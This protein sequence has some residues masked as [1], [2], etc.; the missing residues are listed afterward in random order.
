MRDDL[1][2]A[3]RS[4]RHSPTFTAVALIVLALGIGAATAIF[5]VVDAVVLRGLPFDEHD[6]IVGVLGVDTRRP[7]TFG[8]GNSTTQT[9]LDWRR[10]QESFEGLALV[11]S[12][13]FRLRNEAGEPADARA[14]RITHEFFP[15]L[16]VA[17]LLGRGFTENDEIDGS[18]K[19]VVLSYGFWQRRF[20]GA[21]DVVGKTIDLNEEPW[22]IV[23]VMPRNFQY[24]VG[25]VLPTD[26]YVPQAF[27]DVDKTRGDSHNYNGIAIGRL[28]P[29]I[30]IAQARDQMNRVAVALDQQYPKWEPGWR[31]D[32]I[33]LHHYLVGKVRPWML[34]LLGA[35]GL[36]LL[37]ACA[38]VA[39]LMLARATVRT[40][41]IG[42]RAALGATR[43]RLIR[44]LI[45]EGL[46]LSLLGA[47]I[48]VALAYFGVQTIRA[49]LPTGLPRVASIAID[50]RVL[51]AA[52]GAAI[53]TGLVF[54][55]V[56]AFQSSRPDLTAA[57]KETGRSVTSSGA[58]QRL[59]SALVIAEVAL[60]VVLLVGA[61]LF[62]SSFVS[63]VRIDPGF[64]YHNI[65]TFSIA[66]RFPPGMPTEERIPAG[67][68]YLEEMLEA[69]RRVPGVQG[70]GMVQ[71]GLPLTGSWS[72][73]RPT[74]P[75]RGELASDADSIDRRVVTSEYLQVLRIPLLRGRLLNDQ[76]RQGTERVVVIND[77][78]AKW[79]WPGQDALGQRLT[80]NKTELTVVGIVGNIH[81]LG[82]ESPPR[83]ESYVPLAQEPASAAAV[84]IRTHGNPIAIYPA[85]KAAI[86]AINPEQRLSN[87][88][89]TLEAYMDRLIAQRR[90]NMALLALFGLLGL[91]IATV[92]IYGVMAYVVAQR[93]NEIGVR[94]ALGASRGTVLTM[95]LR[96]AVLLIV[97]GLAIG[98]AGAWFLSASIKSFL[99]QIEPTNLSVFVGALSTLTVAGLLASAIP[100]HRAATID[101]LSALRHE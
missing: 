91:V 22:E 39:N 98:G 89:L 20:G 23:G 43:W 51:G 37:I 85:I 58:S 84:A 69:I 81:H 44:G 99:F 41:E 101:P 83:Q 29:G 9:Y 68:A 18:H 82:P 95:V 33:T 16:R 26:I 92:G 72:R 14:Q 64:D 63:L 97:A 35:V 54:G 79:Y 25:V 8:G 73:T 67:R 65:L 15:V 56:P 61:G 28:K 34:M 49:W 71:G 53:A 13:S 90:F 1:R 74:L 2:A 52:V 24:P 40:R 70:V 86:W 60:A 77:A 93:T 32:V 30:S 48:G 17:P 96:R 100:A 55:I 21:P 4:L 5:S 6:R 80:I 3:L 42:I 94:I 62:M 19:K 47:A 7:A 75:G 36:V 38:N 57:L 66:K 10:R 31:V 88:M 59:R 46:V 11:G 87:D 45:V 78:A 12:S 27:R 50:L 76:D